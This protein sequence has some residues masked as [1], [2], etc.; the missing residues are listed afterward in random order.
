LA[1][2]KDTDRLDTAGTVKYR[3]A[4]RTQCM[5]DASGRTHIVQD[6]YSLQD[7]QYRI[8]A[9]RQFKK[10]RIYQDRWDTQCRIRAG[11]QDK[12]FR[13]LA[14]NIHSAEYTQA[15]RTHSKR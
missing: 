2:N 1:D 6:T 9:C 15:G 7:R 3:V 12:G 10:S 14:G 11:R 5:I 13:I 8:H 4:S